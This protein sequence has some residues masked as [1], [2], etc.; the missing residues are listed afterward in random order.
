MDTELFWSALVKRRG[1]IKPQRW[2]FWREL[3][4]PERRLPH[5]PRR[6]RF[7]LAATPASGSVEASNP[8]RRRTGAL[9]LPDC[10]IRHRR[11]RS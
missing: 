2:G 9:D 7:P 11:F 6:R 8:K 1:R 3:R 5:A 4:E 10:Q